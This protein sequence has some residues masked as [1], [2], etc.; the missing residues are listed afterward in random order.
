[1]LPTS[2]EHSPGNDKNFS[3][4]RRKVWTDHQPGHLGSGTLLQPPRWRRRGLF[5]RCRADEY[6]FADE[7]GKMTLPEPGSLEDHTP[8]ARDIRAHQV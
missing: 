6:R 5:E 4:H 3:Y 8:S 1:M 7:P 2:I